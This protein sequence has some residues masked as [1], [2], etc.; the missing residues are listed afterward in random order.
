MITTAIVPALL[1]IEPNISKLPNDYSILRKRRIYPLNPIL[2]TTGNNWRTFRKRTRIY[3]TLHVR[4]TKYHPH[5]H[6]TLPNKQEQR[7]PPPPPPKKNKTKK[8]NPTPTPSHPHIPSNINPTQITHTLRHLGLHR[9]L[10]RPIPPMHRPAEQAVRGRK[11]RAARPPGPADRLRLV[12]VVGFDWD[13][14][15]Q[16]GAGGV[17][18]AGGAGVSFW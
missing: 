11:P 4:N 2:P 5:T 13:G 7:T 9:P 1:G 12:L 17:V 15:A 10:P 14:L 18:E 3:N 6:L 8:T 16:V